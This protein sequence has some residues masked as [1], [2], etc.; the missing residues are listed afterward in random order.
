MNRQFR[1]TLLVLCA[2]ALGGCG[3]K[4][5]LYF[6]PAQPAAA[7]PKAPDV[8]DVQAPTQAPDAPMP[9]TAPAAKAGPAH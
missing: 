9:E 3:L 2:M 8:Y 5:P 7:A 1:S 6:P 4:G